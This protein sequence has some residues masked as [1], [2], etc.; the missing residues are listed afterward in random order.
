M[1]TKVT[2]HTPTR[3]NLDATGTPAE[4]AASLAAPEAT[5][6]LAGY[7]GVC[8]TCLGWHDEQDEPL[9]DSAEVCPTC[10][11]A[12]VEWQLSCEIDTLLREMRGLEA[13]DVAIRAL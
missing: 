13:L 12:S 6:G 10:G 11:E 5:D 2:S 8:P 9:P 7:L 4:M 1:T 3:S